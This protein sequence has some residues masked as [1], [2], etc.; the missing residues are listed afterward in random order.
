M[1][2]E[3][4]KQI[5]EILLDY[6][7]DKNCKELSDHKVLKGVVKERLLKL[8]NRLIIPVHICSNAAKENE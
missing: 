8:V 3:L 7:T 1:A 5:D 4:E 2:N 6:C